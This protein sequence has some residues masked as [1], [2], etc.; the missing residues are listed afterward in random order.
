MSLYPTLFATALLCSSLCSVLG[1]GGSQVEMED[2]GLSG[3]ISFSTPDLSDDD[4]HSQWMPDQ[5]KCDACTGIAYQVLR[6]D[7]FNFNCLFI[8]LLPVVPPPH[9]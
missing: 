1:G 8:L 4:S 7:T 6:Y 2:D 9:M 3:K 5:L